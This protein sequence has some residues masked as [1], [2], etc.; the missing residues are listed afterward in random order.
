LNKRDSESR[1][2]GLDVPEKGEAAATQQKRYTVELGR[3]EEESRSS[4]VSSGSSKKQKR[5]QQS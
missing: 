4:C 3:E 2:F 5:E 1:F